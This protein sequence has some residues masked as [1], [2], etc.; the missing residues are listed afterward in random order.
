MVL[1]PVTVDLVSSGVSQVSIV[2]LFGGHTQLCSEPT[3]TSVLRDHSAIWE[4][5][6]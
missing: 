1:G 2:V 3:P 6:D 5:E 4:A